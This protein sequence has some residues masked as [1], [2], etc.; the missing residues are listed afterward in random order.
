[1]PLLLVDV[2]IPP[3]GTVE[4]LELPDGTEWFKGKIATQLDMAD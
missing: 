2:K 4:M 3:V 1:M